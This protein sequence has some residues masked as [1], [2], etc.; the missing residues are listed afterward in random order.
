MPPRR[1][2]AQLIQV[3][4]SGRPWPGVPMT[5][6][7]GSR[8]SA[9]VST[10]VWPSAMIVCCT[11]PRTHPWGV[12]RHQECRELAAP[13]PV[14]AGND[15]GELHKRRARDQVLGAGQDPVVAL[16]ARG[17]LEGEGIGPGAG[18]G[19]RERD[20][21]ASGEEIAELARPRVGTPIAD[22]MTRAV[23]PGEHP[24]H[25]P[26]AVAVDLLLDIE[27][28][29][30]PEPEPVGR[31]KVGAVQP[32]PGRGLLHAALQIDHGV[33]Q[34]SVGLQGKRGRA[35]FAPRPPPPSGGPAVRMNSRTRSIVCRPA[36]E[37]GYRASKL[38][39][40]HA[41]TAIRPTAPEVS[42]PICQADTPRRAS[43]SQRRGESG[44]ARR[45]ATAHRS[46]ADRAAGPRRR[47]ARPG[48]HR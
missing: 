34:T 13:G 9:K 43:S 5:A 47:P 41:I 35:E 17:G 27:R 48:R 42:R 23:G 7:A 33:G 4:T 44:P 46:S 22:Q 16:A 1:L 8:T 28:V 38:G 25:S 20:V 36:S 3:N 30:E 26:Q 2:R 37:G 12:H 15:L 18:F 24:L 21:R 19:Q 29:D 45:R 32:G 31:G 10:P 39:R 6:L 40:S 11:G 14:D